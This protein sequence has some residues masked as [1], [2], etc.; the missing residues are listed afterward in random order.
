MFIVRHVA[1][2]VRKYTKLHVP[3][4]ALCGWVCNRDA[5]YR[6]DHSLLFLFMQRRRIPHDLLSNEVLC[7]RLCESL[8]VG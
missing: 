7:P 3:L 6:F 4:L 8:A 5:V 2:G 1:V